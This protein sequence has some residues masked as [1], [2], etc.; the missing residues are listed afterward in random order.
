MD[1][2]LSLIT[3]CPWMLQKEQSMCL[4]AVFSHLLLGETAVILLGYIHMIDCKLL[5]N[6]VSSLKAAV[7]LNG[8]KR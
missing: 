6:A 4:E 2:S 7:V 1:H 5:T 8:M 3:R